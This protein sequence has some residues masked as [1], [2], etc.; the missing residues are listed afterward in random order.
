M[1]VAS[2]EAMIIKYLTPLHYVKHFHGNLC[3]HEMII[4]VELRIIPV[5]ILCFS[6]VKDIFTL[7]W[8]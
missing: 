1:P 4:E 3:I 6:P 7:I 8:L 5:D 2:S